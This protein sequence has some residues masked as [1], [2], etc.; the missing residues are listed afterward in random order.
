MN[1]LTPL[2]VAETAVTA[3]PTAVDSPPG[4]VDKLT[5]L[6]ERFQMS[7][8]KLHSALREGST[9]EQLSAARGVSLDSLRQAVAD[10]VAQNRA[11]IGRPP[12]SGKTLDNITVQILSGHFH[13]HA[14]G[15]GN[16]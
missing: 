11:A 3:I 2:P 8:G 6:A 16:R 12:L 10:R 9:I 13:Q 4:W 1:V 15:P 14:D 7:P 5:M